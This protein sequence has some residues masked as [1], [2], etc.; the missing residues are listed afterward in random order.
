MHGHEG[1][2]YVGMGTQHIMTIVGKHLTD[3]GPWGR[4]D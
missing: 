1:L 2:G 4:K 3:I